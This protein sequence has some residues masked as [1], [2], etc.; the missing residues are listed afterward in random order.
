M[1]RRTDGREKTETILYLAGSQDLD[2]PVATSK[3]VPSR[4][5][6]AIDRSYDNID[7]LRSSGNYGI[8]AEAVDVLRAWPRTVNVCAVILDFCSGL[9]DMQDITMLHVSLMF[10]PA[11]V[12]AVI[13]FNCQRGRDAQANDWRMLSERQ[14]MALRFNDV[15]PKHR[16]FAFALAMATFGCIATKHEPSEVLTC[17]DYLSPKLF[18]YKSSVLTFDSVVTHPIASP[19]DWAEAE[20]EHQDLRVA[21]DSAYPR[22]QQIA[23]KIAATLATRTRRVNRA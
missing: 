15:D 1:L 12:N 14:A 19:F 16:G 13:A 8:C 18:S 23:R 22:D 4:N 3:G 6:V 2:R 11:L 10:N 17:L 7:T 21:I 5:L 20:T 9:L